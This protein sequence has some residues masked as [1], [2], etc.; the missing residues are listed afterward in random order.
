MSTAKVLP[1]KGTMERERWDAFY[2]GVCCTLAAGFYLDNGTG[3]CY[4]EVVGSVGARD[5]LN[6]A[7]RDGDPELP[8]IRRAVRWLER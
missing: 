7:R 3:T 8:N 5:L 6:Y 1:R 4:L 2:A